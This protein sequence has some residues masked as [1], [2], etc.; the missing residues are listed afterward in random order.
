MMRLFLALVCVSG[1]LLGQTADAPANLLDS[2]IKRKI[3]GFA[4]H[5]S[6]YAKNLDTGATYALD[7]DSPVRTS[8][9]S[10]DELPSS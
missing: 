7:A 6:L 9:A 5:V 4:G 10:G 8:T 1:L 2:K 3:A